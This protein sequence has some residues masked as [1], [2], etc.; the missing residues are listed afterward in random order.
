MRS[1]KLIASS[2]LTGFVLNLAAVGQAVEND[3]SSAK[4]GKETLQTPESRRELGNN[5]FWV[6]LAGL[7]AGAAFERAGMNTPRSASYAVW[8][9]AWS[10]WL[11]S[12]GERWFSD[13]EDYHSYDAKADPFRSASVQGAIGESSNL[14]L[15][16]DGIYIHPLYND[17]SGGT[18][19]FLTGSI[20]LGML[21]SFDAFSIE[22][23]MYWRLITPSFKS[24][25]GSDPLPEPVGRY[26]DW[27]ELKT[28]VSKQTQAFGTKFRNQVTLGLSDIGDKGGKDI[29][30]NIHWLTRNSLDHLDY[31]D[32][33]E[34]RF[35]TLGFESGVEGKLCQDGLP[36]AYQ[37]L[38]LQGESSKMMRELGIQ[39]NM[40]IIVLP[41]WWEN[42]T[43]VRVIRQLQSD[44]YGRIKP[45][46]YE[47][48][49]GVRLFS[50]LTP[51]VKYVSP[52]LEGDD[53]GQTY[54]DL[55]HY[56]VAF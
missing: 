32:Q 18:D 40:N 4:F 19:K 22:S 55:I 37:L 48:A 26:A 38:S 34:G 49:V 20:K 3:E 46:R 42:A 11:G 53:V 8:G 17:V 1:V 47:G 31:T 21:H 23:V 15:I 29:H 16:P 44:V 36:C 51:T 39:W 7:L 43:E 56:N 54:F 5:A 14:H 35:V 13:G 24:Q 50:V 28:A 41:K 27:T 33:P 6:G 9:L 30:R 10:A 2:I 45:W 12:T 25:F 52:Y